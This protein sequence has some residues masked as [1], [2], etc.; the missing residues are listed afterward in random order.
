VA[1]ETNGLLQ[2]LRPKTKTLSWFTGV[3]TGGYLT[4][5]S[6]SLDEAKRKL[7]L[8]HPR[9]L[10]PVFNEIQYPIGVPIIA[11]SDGI[12]VLD[13][14]HRVEYVAA[15]G[16]TAEWEFLYPPVSLSR[17]SWAWD[18]ALSSMSRVQAAVLGVGLGAAVRSALLNN[19]PEVIGV[20]RLVAYSMKDLRLSKMP[21]GLRGVANA[22]RF[23]WAVETFMPDSIL[24]SASMRRDFLMKLKDD[25]LIILD[26]QPYPPIEETIN[27]IFLFNER[28]DIMIRR[29]VPVDRWPEEIEILYRRV[30]IIDLVIVRSRRA[31][32]FFCTIARSNSGIRRGDIYSRLRLKNALSSAP[33]CASPD[34]W[35]KSANQ[36][37]LILSEII[38]LDLK[39]LR[40]ARLEEARLSGLI[41]RTMKSSKYSGWTKDLARL[42]FCQWMIES[43]GDMSRATEALATQHTTIRMKDGSPMLIETSVTLSR[44]IRV[45]CPRM[46]RILELS[47]IRDV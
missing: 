40:S 15:I 37:V 17:H 45:G 4:V 23:R 28:H 36:I 11:D 27:Q 44:F 25:A 47:L 39:T 26:I 20:D 14:L 34:D 31:V 29:I 8:M 21:A 1:R 10:D 24:S 12:T 22:K 41:G 16:D 38:G 7:R 6:E 43:K 2:F 3:V 32:Q 35:C 18:L 33:I 42:W 9:A 46:S 5:A 30:P 13:R 19:C